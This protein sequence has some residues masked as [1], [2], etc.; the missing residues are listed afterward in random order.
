MVRIYLDKFNK[1]RLLVPVPQKL[2]LPP[3]KILEVIMEEPFLTQ[4][5]LQGL[6]Q[7]NIADLDSVN[8]FFGFSPLTIKENLIL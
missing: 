3:V 8:R 5:E 7:K 6:S 1:K 4:E 2:L